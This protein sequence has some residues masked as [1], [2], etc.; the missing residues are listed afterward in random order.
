MILGMPPEV[1]ILRIP[2]ILLALTIH[3]F[4]HGYMAFK[5][6][7]STARDAGR[8]TLNPISHLDPLGAIMLMTG[9]FGWAKP[10]PVNGYN[11]LKPKRDIVLVSIA[12]PLS[13]I[14]MAIV[15]GM[16]IRFLGYS[17]PAALQGHLLTLLWLGFFL[18]VGIAFFN[19]LPFPPL[20]GSKIAM[21]FM[22]DKYIPKYL[23]M[24]RHV[25]IIFIILIVAGTIFDSPILSLVLNPVYKP[26]VGAIQFI[27][28]GKVL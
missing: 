10:V 20:D 1:F 15:F 3:E 28:F 12:G 11:L 19:L 7:D 9:V 27:T 18:N 6:G 22:P 2:I 16:I 25:L 21:G 5:L 13:N 23:H 8:L 24:T 26:F 4:A 14:A 17:N